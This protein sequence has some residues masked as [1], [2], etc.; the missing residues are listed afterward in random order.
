MK[1]NE[2]G[3]CLFGPVYRAAFAY[4]LCAGM[5]HNGVQQGCRGLLSA[6]CG[7]GCG[8]GMVSAPVRYRRCFFPAKTVECSG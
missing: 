6:Q 2:R 7:K 3:G 5:A 8:N 4:A 1:L